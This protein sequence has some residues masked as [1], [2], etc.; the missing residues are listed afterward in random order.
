MAAPPIHRANPPICGE[1]PRLLILGTFPSPLSREKRE[2]YGNPR[3]QFWRILFGVFGEPFDNPDYERK[4]ALLIQ[5][6]IALWDVI[7]ECEAEGALDSAIR[8]PVYNT[9]LPGFIIEHGIEKVFFNGNNAYLFFRRGIGI[10]PKNILPS[11]SPAHAGMRFE[12]KLQR[13]RKGLGVSIYS[14]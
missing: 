3:N 2:Y 10:A 8:N 9:N 13:W 14:E 11:T 12:E 7:A 1:N 5:N 4:K 6:K